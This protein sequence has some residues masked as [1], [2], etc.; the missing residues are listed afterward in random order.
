MNKEK[1]LRFLNNLP[2]R[3]LQGY[4]QL[5]KT[6]DLLVIT[7]SM[8]DLISLHGF[9]IAAVAPASEST[10]C[11]DKQIEEFKNR[12]KHILIVYDH[13]KAGKYN[14]AKIRHKYPELNY[15]IL[16]KTLEKDFT[17]SIALVGV[18]KMKELVK[19]FLTKYKF[20]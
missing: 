10:F 12:F 16:P 2:S 3:K 17:D 5:P 18:D 14:M 1:G 9:G 19:E 20:K 6:G 11:S 4:K 13:D 8:K 7:K 15:Y